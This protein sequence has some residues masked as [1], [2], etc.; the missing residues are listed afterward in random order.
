MCLEEKE[1]LLYKGI[2]NKA[3]KNMWGSYFTKLKVAI[4]KQ[5]N[6]KGGFL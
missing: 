3:D 2:H 6:N 1:K 4:I 5:P